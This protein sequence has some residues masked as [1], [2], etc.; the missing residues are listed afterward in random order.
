MLVTHSRDWSHHLCV[1]LHCSS[2]PL[3]HLYRCV[4][5]CFGAKG[6]VSWLLDAMSVDLANSVLHSL[7]QRHWVNWSCMALGQWH[8]LLCNDHERV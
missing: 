1:V 8:M 5:H 7:L 6:A 4:L 2:F 3:G